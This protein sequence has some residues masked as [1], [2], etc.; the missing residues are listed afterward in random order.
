MHPRGHCCFRRVHLPRECGQH[1]SIQAQICRHRAWIASSGCSRNPRLRE[2]RL[3]CSNASKH[4]SLIHE[5]ISYMC[6]VA[7]IGVSRYYQLHFCLSKIPQ[8]ARFDS[9]VPTSRFM[10]GTEV[11]LTVEGISQFAFIETRNMYSS[12]D[13]T[14][15]PGNNTRIRKQHSL[16]KTH[17]LSRQFLQ[18]SV[19]SFPYSSLSRPSHFKF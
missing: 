2:R 12:T 3:G 15:K 1:L 19:G 6:Q 8:P 4:L 9:T 7:F 11:R 13:Y 18:S 17:Y 10:T 5:T 14:T 16:C